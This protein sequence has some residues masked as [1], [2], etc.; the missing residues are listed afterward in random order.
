MAGITV[1][2]FTRERYPLTGRL[3]GPLGVFGDL[4]QHDWFAS[5]FS[6]FSVIW[7]LVVWQSVPFVALTLRAGLSQIPRS[8]YETAALSGAGGLLQFRRHDGRGVVRYL[9][10]V[11]LELAASER[12]AS[13]EQVV[14]QFVCRLSEG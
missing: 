4:T 10:P 12:P 14:A 7:L 3:N 13:T 9:R 5:S 8:Y 1:L 2:R 6:G 11:K